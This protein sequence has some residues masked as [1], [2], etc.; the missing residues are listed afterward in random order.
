MKYTSLKNLT[1]FQGQLSI[2]RLSDGQ[3]YYGWIRSNLVEYLEE[4]RPQWPVSSV[5]PWSDRMNRTGYFVGDIIT[6]EPHRLV[7]GRPHIVLDD[8]TIWEYK[9][10]DN[11]VV[12]VKHLPSFVRFNIPIDSRIIRSVNPVHEKKYVQGLY[13]HKVRLTKNRFVQ[14]YFDYK[15]QLYWSPMAFRTYPS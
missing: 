6:T 11:Q 1:W 9:V 7:P 5:E 4:P 10:Q 13:E 2:V 15:T 12:L 8:T 3:F 14:A